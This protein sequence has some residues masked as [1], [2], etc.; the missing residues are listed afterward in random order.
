VSVDIGIS[1]ARV[2]EKIAGA[3]ITLLFLWIIL[4]RCLRSKR[5]IDAW[6]GLHKQYGYYAAK[7][8]W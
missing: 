7:L 5:E 3:A 8:F 1:S 6:E 2:E 4:E